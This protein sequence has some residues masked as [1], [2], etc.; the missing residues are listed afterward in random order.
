[1]LALLAFTSLLL[2]ACAA[3]RFFV[4]SEWRDRPASVK[5]V[6]STPA[7][8]NLDDLKQ[9]LPDYQNTF[10]GWLDS[11][12]V[13]NL[14]KVTNNK[15]KVSTMLVGD[16]DPRI[17][18]VDVKLGEEGFK[19]PSFGPLEK[20]AEIYLV[21]RNIW[22]GLDPE[23]EAWK[24]EHLDPNSV[25]LFAPDEAFETKLILKCDYS[26]YDTKT[27]KL[28]AYGS[29]V[30]TATTVQTLTMNDWESA[31]YYLFHNIA[32]GTPVFVP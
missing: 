17:G 5:V 15:V 6:F 7:V 8:G 29:S 18:F 20:D 28:L 16:D 22:M 24:K 23:K 19:A 9:I 27:G 1:M 26:Y 12:M 11:Q 13:L 32:W 14:G 21:L 31:M 30:G 10:K 2:S 4:D 3:P 25:N